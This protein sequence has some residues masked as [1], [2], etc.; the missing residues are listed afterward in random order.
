MQKLLQEHKKN[1]I[2]AAAAALV[3]L[4]V[5]CVVVISRASSPYASVEP[6]GGTV[7]GNGPVTTGNDVAASGGKY[8]QL[9]PKQ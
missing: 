9:A 2:L 4:I 8:V 3:I 7:G 1:V 5:G 6:E